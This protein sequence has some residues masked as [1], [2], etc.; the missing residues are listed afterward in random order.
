MLYVSRF[1]LRVNKLKLWNFLNILDQ[2]WILSWALLIIQSTFL[3]DALSD[4]FFSDSLVALGV[5][6]HILELVYKSIVESVLTFH[7]PIWYEHLNCRLKNKLSRIVSSA[8]KIIGRPQNQLTQLY[9]ERTKK[10][11]R[12]ILADGSHPLFSQFELLKSGKSDRVPLAKKKWSLSSLMQLESLIQQLLIEQC[13]RLEGFFFL[14]V[15]VTSYCVF[16]CML[17]FCCV[18][19]AK[20]NFPLRWTIKLYNTIQYNTIALGQVLLTNVV[21]F[22]TISVLFVSMLNLI[23]WPWWFL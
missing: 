19:W 11:T 16:I 6:K 1:H 14:Y 18:W 2:F 22:S 4:F 13:V 3:R 5:S 17:L 12:V 9:V 21:F 20:D 15:Y 7:L 8:N 10:K 23:T